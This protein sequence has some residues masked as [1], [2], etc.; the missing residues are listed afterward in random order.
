[1]DK[2][3]E[4]ATRCMHEAS[5]WDQNSWITLTYDD[6]NIDP[7]GSLV[8]RDLQLFFKRLRSHFDGDTLRYY[9]CGE[10]G[11]EL[12]R[13]HYHACLFGIDFPDKKRVG[14]SEHGGIRYKSDTLTELWGKG[15]T[16]VG[17]LTWQS[18]A[19]TARYCMKKIHGELAADHYGP[20]HPE[21]ARMSN[22]PGIGAEWFRRYQSSVSEHDNVVSFNREVKVPRY[23]DK[24]RERQGENLDEVKRTRRRKALERA[25]DHT[26]ERMRVRE[27]CAQYRARNLKRGLET[28]E[29][30][31]LR[32]L[33]PA[34][35][36]LS[37]TVLP[38]GSRAGDS[39]GR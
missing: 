18:A 35:E 28:D 30:Q 12:G 39:H 10:Y 4:W 9:A 2:A 19:Y 38:A 22:R 24:L 7:V 29:D 5:L 20:R 8:P 14:R 23:Y 26:P 34:G 3:Q 33:R 31:N 11:A 1:M 21:F 6:Q 37:A 32:D 36:S 17:E 25:A 27:L 13:P 16:E 15:F